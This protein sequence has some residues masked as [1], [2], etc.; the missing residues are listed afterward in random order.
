MLRRSGFE[1][2]WC[3]WIAHCI[4]LVQFLVL[5]NGFPHAS[6]AALMTR[7][8]GTL[9]LFCYLFVIVIEVLGGMISAAISGDLLSSASLGT[10][11]DISHL[12]FVMIPYFFIG[13]TQIIYAIYGVYSYYLK[14]VGLKT[15]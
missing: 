15:N 8:K 1:G 10:G 4:S 3:L 12:L 5:V 6:L 7:G 11:I 14:S 13:L 9:R 2:K